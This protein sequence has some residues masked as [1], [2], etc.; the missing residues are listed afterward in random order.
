MRQIA[1]DH[2]N[3]VN[4]RLSAASGLVGAA[5]LLD[6]VEMIPPYKLSLSG[7]HAM[8]R[9]LERTGFGDPNLRGATTHAAHGDAKSQK[10][11]T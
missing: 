4:E 9:A 2:Q 3:A 10:E 7:H 5:S 11:L 1:A 6:T 8:G